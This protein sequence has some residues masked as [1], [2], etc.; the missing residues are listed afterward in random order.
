M[1]WSVANALAVTVGGDFGRVQFTPDLLPS[2][3]VGTSV[4]NQHE[5]RFEFRA[6]P[7]FANVV[8][9]DEVN[10]SSPKTQSALLEAMAEQQVTTD[11]VTRALPRPF[12]VLATQNPL[13]YHGTYPLPESQLDRFLLKVSI[14]YPARADEALILD[15]E[16]SHPALA[17][18][19]P[20]VGPAHVNA[21]ADHCRRVHVSRALTDYLLDLAAATRSHRSLSLG[22]STRATLGLQR[23][24]Q[25]RAAAQSRD[26]A[27]ADDVKALALPI[28]AHRLVVAPEAQIQSVDATAVLTEILATVPV[29]GDG[30]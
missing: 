9:A 11:G 17:T 28:L 23:A 1:S 30:A 29:P 16:G 22:M 13:E 8:L 24:A 19:R 2:D 12:M 26:Y 4:W 15:T 7:V 25:V 10:R 21:M 20:V 14:G 27:I 3:V 5:G 18:L 6:G